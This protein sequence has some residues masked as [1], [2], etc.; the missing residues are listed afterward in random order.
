MD[1]F[2]AALSEF[3]NEELLSKLK[4]LLNLHKKKTIH[5]FEENLKEIEQTSLGSL[6]KEILKDINVDDLQNTLAGGGDS[7]NIGNLFSA[8]QDS[9]NGLGKVINTVSQSMIS[10]LSSGQINQE[11]L[12]KDAMS[13]ATKLPGMLPGG[14]GSQLGNI[15]SMLQQFQQMGGADFMKDMGFS[16]AQRNAA[17]SRM[18]SAS[19]KQKTTDRLRKKL[20]K[21]KENNIQTEVEEHH[22]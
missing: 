17:G 11:E 6:A 21:Q 12:L 13:L 8:L 2:E 5:K 22:D 7:M 4:H 16:G 18:H 20:D 19:R 9:N 10:K 1:E 15:G 3:T 14:M